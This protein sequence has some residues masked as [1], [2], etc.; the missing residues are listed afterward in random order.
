MRG[1]L[2]SWARCVAAAAAVTALAPIAGRAGDGC[3]KGFRPSTTT[4]RTFHVET[5]KIVQAAMPLPADGWRV[6]EE[7]EVR[8]PRL[9]CIGQEASPLPLAYQIAYRR[10]GSSTQGTSDGPAPGE[11]ATDARIDIDVNPRGV[12]VS[13]TIETMNVPGTALALRSGP[14]SSST[15]YLLF[16]DWSV[17]AIGSSTSLATAHL[18]SDRPYTNVQALAVRI[19]GDREGADALAGRIRLDALSALVR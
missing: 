12:P 5:L 19:R 7:T 2:D 11:S 15:V 13:E 14:A 6:V 16:G 3:Y 17:E 18:A 9:M 1:P 8:P 10:A 4:E